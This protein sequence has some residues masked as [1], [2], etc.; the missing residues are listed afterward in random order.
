[1]TA[2]IIGPRTLAQLQH[3]LPIAE[4]ALPDELRAAC[5]TLVAPG[6][7]VASH[8]NSAQWMRWKLA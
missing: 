2:P 7:V 5:D 3:A 4:M 6:S 8:F 1:M